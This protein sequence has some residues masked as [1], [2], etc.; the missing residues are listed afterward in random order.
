M[1]LGADGEQL[2]RALGD[3][4]AYKSRDPSRFKRELF[5]LGGF[6]EAFGGRPGQQNL[7]F[8]YEGCSKSDF[9]LD[10]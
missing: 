10:G 6:W 1:A 9:G 3:I 7:A 5:D 8:S 2:G 4:A